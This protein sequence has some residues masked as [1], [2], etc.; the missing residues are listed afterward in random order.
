MVC[1]KNLDINKA[2]T[3]KFYH[4]LA[5]ATV[6]RVAPIWGISLCHLSGAR[7]GNSAYV[8]VVMSSR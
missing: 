1:F 8:V 6:A 2:E 4:G 7:A 3:V 5:S